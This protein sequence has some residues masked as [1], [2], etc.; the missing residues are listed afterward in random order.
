MEIGTG[1][2]QAA[3]VVDD[4]LYGR[5]VESAID[6]DRRSRMRYHP[7]TD[8]TLDSALLDHGPDLVGDVRQRVTESRGNSHCLIHARSPGRIP[9]LRCATRAWRLRSARAPAR[10][11]P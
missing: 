2:N 10:S 7:E 3:H 1:R 8:A 6:R 5:R 9:S 11:L 4:V